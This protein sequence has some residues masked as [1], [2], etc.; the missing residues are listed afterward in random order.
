MTTSSPRELLVWMHLAASSL[1]TYDGAVAPTG[2]SK[3]ADRQARRRAYKPA[4][5]RSLST[6]TNLSS[7]LSPPTQPPNPTNNIM[8]TWRSRKSFGRFALPNRYKVADCYDPTC[9]YSDANPNRRRG[10]RGSGA[11]GGGDNRRGGGGGGRGP[12]GGRGRSLGG[13]G[14][15]G[16]G[17]YGVT[18]AGFRSWLGFRSRR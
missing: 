10:R 16:A 18:V 2:L 13:R 7:F 6:T 12:S 11:G 3:E 8:C 5:R 9:P 15:G 14:A 17:G 1:G 4:P